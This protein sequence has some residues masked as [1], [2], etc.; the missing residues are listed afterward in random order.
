MKVSDQWKPGALKIG[1][2][3]VPVDFSAHSLKAVK[4]ATA[5]ASGIGAS[6]I[7][8]HV[9]DDPGEEIPGSP[10][11]TRSY[12]AQQTKLTQSAEHQLALWAKRE[13]RSYAA[14]KQYVRRGRIH[15]VIVNLAE[16]SGSGLIVIGSR[17]RTGLS[18]LLLGSVAESVVHSAHCPVLIVH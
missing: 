4:H 6:V 5:L 7:L 14:V 13:V 8:L 3:L 15:R 1:K 17:G 2:I 11:K 16:K 12:L 9:I 18:R 10:L